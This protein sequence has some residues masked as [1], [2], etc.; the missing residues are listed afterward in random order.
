MILLCDGNPPVENGCRY[1]I[2][3]ENLFTR[4]Y[5]TPSLFRTHRQELQPA[6]EWIVQ[7]FIEDVATQVTSDKVRKAG[8][9]PGV[10]TKPFTVNTLKRFSPQSILQGDGS[11]FCSFRGRIRGALPPGHIPR[12]AVPT[13][14]DGINHLA[15]NELASALRHGRNTSII[16]R[17]RSRFPS[18]RAF[19]DDPALEY[20]LECLL[21]APET[22][23]PETVVPETPAPTQVL[24]RMPRRRVRA[25]AESIASPRTSFPARLESPQTPLYEAVGLALAAVYRQGG[26]VSVR[27]SQGPSTPSCGGANIPGAHGTRGIAQSHSDDDSEDAQELEWVLDGAD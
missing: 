5:V 16:K 10:G 24:P 22:P 4:V 6:I 8:L 9:E 15:L 2:N 21:A 25:D 13:V 11:V 14:D 27:P 7:M 23:A 12:G 17:L 3:P 19:L 26:F 18:F 20:I 1:S